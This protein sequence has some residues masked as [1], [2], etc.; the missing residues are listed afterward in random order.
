MISGLD[1]MQKG[2]KSGEKRG[3]GEGGVS[4]KSD[5]LYGS[6]AQIGWY[7]PHNQHI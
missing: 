1:A 4:K 7:N 3:K 2:K 6:C 5:F